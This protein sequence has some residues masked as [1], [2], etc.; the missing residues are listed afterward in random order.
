MKAHCYRPTHLVPILDLPAQVFH[1]VC[2]AA[3]DIAIQHDDTVTVLGLVPGAA[4]LCRH[5]CRFHHPGSVVVIPDVVLVEL[6]ANGFD[7]TA[8]TGL[9][10]ADGRTVHLFRVPEDVAARNT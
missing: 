7:D 2:S 1:Q 9:Q 8:T 5:S 3:A 10:R 6:M 4:V